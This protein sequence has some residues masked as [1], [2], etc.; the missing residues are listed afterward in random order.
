MPQ[1][2]VTSPAEGVYI[3]PEFSPAALAAFSTR[4]FEASR[5]LPC[6]L[7]SLGTDPHRFATVKQV[8]GDKIVV[9][10][11]PL[12][13]IEADALVTQERNLPLMIRTADCAPVFLFDPVQEAVGICHAGWQGVQKGIVSRTVE[14]LQKEFGSKP[15]SLKVGI[16]PAIRAECYEVGGEFNDY[17]PGFIQSQGEKYFFNL[18]GAVGKQLR[19][20]GV[21]ETAVIDSGICTACSVDRFFSARREKDQAGR[22]ISLVMLK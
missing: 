13:G 4:G 20:A 19:D 11:G 17:F 15:S 22:F 10:S 9:A 8:Q 1:E 21:R 3:F 2:I 12:E 5:D 6:F 7:Q 16:G 14:T 18:V